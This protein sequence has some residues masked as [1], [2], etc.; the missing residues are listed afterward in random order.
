LALSDPVELKDDEAKRFLR[1]LENPV[2]SE[3]RAIM[4]KK[5]EQAAELLTRK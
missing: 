3:K 1:D 2:H 5:A 4:L